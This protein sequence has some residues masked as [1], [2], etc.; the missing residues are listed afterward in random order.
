VSGVDTVRVRPAE[1]R[2]AAGI[3]ALGP[4]LAEGAAP[5]RPAEAFA[6]AAQGWLDDAV[7]AMGA[8]RPVWVAESGGRVVGVVAALLSKHFT[9]DEDCY[10]GELAVDGEFEGRGVGRALVAV[11]ERWAQERGVG[12]V[13][14]ETGGANRRA[15]EFY[16]ALGYAEE[17]VQLTKV[18]R[19]GS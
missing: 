13:T 9:G 17:Q 16:A 18:L 12:R 10:L 19:A 7:D 11:V 5:W 1:P 6:K 14:L 8:E 15:R 3:R 2:D 4:R